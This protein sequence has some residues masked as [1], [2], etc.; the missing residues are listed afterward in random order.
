MLPIRNEISYLAAPFWDPFGFLE[1]EIFFFFWVPS[2]LGLVV[3]G[4]PSEVVGG[5]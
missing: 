5:I 1:V 3:S 4:S 2:L